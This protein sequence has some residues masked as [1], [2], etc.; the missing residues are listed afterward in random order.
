M[1]RGKELAA[2]TALVVASVV[3]GLVLLELGYRLAKET[4]S[5][6]QEL[7]HADT[8]ALAH[9]AIP[10]P[11]LGF[12]PRPGGI[13]RNG[14]FDDDGFRLAPAM[15]PANP[16]L[17]V[18]TGDSFTLGEEVA[19]DETW[20]AILQELTGVR[21]INAGVSAYGI[22]QTV[23]RTERLAATLAPTAM[24]VGFIADD[25]WRTEMRRLWDRK[26]PYF[27]GD[28]GVLVLQAVAEPATETGSASSLWD[29]LRQSA[30]VNVVLGG[31]A[32]LDDW[33]Y[34]HNE[35]LGDNVRAL[36]SGSGE[37]ISC[38]LMHRLAEAGVPILVVAQYDL[39]FWARGPN[40]LAELRRQSLMVL[41]CASAAGLA[42]LD[43]FGMLKE[44]I[45]H[46]GLHS[47]YLQDHHSAFGN[48]L[49]AQ[50]IAEALT[51][52]GM[53]KVPMQRPRNSP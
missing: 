19:N 53:L 4:L 42:T 43:T 37:E 8:P 35:W 39:N 32:V 21:V 27:V 30:L 15:V 26:K 34:S 6:L 51:V 25:I 18:A 24:V 10:D 49:V 28:G 52:R 40:H 41:G 31:L 45:R 50:S 23:L 5:L 44:A 22:D 7:D 12:V 48:G 13:S 36:P 14:P 33:R 9:W 11:L 46:S 38:A 2:R 3:M 1:T 47:L 16:G 17:V 29:L 20:P